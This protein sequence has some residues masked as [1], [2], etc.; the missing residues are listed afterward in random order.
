VTN[1]KSGSA[2]GGEENHRPKGRHGASPPT[3]PGGLE[4]GQLPASTS[5]AAQTASES[6]CDGKTRARS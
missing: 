4:R 1:R 5:L 2:G 6:G 3:Q